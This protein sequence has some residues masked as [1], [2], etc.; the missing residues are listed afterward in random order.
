M[1]SAR[2][3]LIVRDL[4]FSYGQ[5]PLFRGLSCSVA[6]GVVLHL[7][8]PNGVGKSTLLSLVAGL[9]RFDSGDVGLMCDGETR[10]LAPAIEFLSAD[11]NGLFPKLDAT[12]NL[13]FWATLR[14]LTLTADEIAHALQ[15]WGLGHRQVRE[16][17]AVS[18]FSTGMRRRLGLARVFLSRAPCLLLDEPTHALDVEGTRLFEAQLLRHREQNGLAIVVSHTAPLNPNL[19]NQTLL[20]PGATDV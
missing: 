1:H 13:R 15:V 2:F 6:S 19:F 3:E 9:R 10:P 5:V 12:S 20:L 4:T 7:A 8:G 14:G 11:G 18:K 16:T 17:L